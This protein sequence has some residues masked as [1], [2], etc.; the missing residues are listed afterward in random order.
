MADNSNKRVFYFE[1]LMDPVYASIVER[2]PGVSLTKLGYA[3]P[4]DANWAVIRAAH[5]YQITSARDELPA[6]YVADEPFLKRAPGLLVVSTHGAGYDTVDVEACTRAGV[7]VVHQAGGNREAVAEH[8]IAMMLTLAK[9]LIMADRL[10]RRQTIANRTAFI[11]NDMLGKTIGIVGLGNVGSRVAELCGGLL[12]MRVLACDPYLT[13]EQCSARGAEKADLDDVLHLADVV[14]INCP[15]TRE[16]AGL[17]G[18]RAFALLKP[19]AYFIN[20]AR[21]G[22]HDEAAL[23]DALR[24]GRLAGAG[25]DVWDI[26]PPPLDHP[27]LAFD[28]VIASPHTAGI[29]IES[30]HKIATFGAE[31]MLQV[32][33][34]HRP[35]RLLNPEAWPAYAR[36]Y[37]AAF[38]APPAG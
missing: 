16:T 7:I 31:Q 34:G 17:I 30:R 27:L 19:S 9:R 8:V 24:T 15:L 35:P 23:A 1:R 32:L 10:M 29:T 28:N 38:G 13:P 6:D 14:S 22:I 11:G 20:T 3:S 36:R 5:A 26:E 4:A 18:D 37:A 21:G 2:H 33:D 25:L 12:A